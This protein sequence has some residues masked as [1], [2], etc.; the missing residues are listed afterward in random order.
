M[1]VNEG[2]HALI[3]RLLGQR[4]ELFLSALLNDVRVVVIVSTMQTLSDSWQPNLVK[5]GPRMTILVPQQ[6]V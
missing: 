4:L 6:L 1:E 3:A 5:Y 2:L